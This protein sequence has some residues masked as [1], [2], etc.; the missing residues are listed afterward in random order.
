MLAAVGAE[1]GALGGALLGFFCGWP[2]G[3]ALGLPR[4]RL[5]NDPEGF[6]TLDAALIAL[7]VGW[8]TGAVVGSRLA[9]RRRSRPSRAATGAAAIGLAFLALGATMVGS[10]NADW[11]DPIVFFAAPPL[12]MALA[13]V[14]GEG[15]AVQGG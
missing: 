8:I 5:F 6:D 12:L 2:I 9:T 13:A 1:F 10:G 14:I 11:Y 15:H 3:V 7:V 4:Y